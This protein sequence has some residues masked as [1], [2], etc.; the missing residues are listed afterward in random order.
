[1]QYGV[2]TKKV[3]GGK[4]L[5]VKSVISDH[6]VVESAY[7]TGDF[8]LHPE[9]ALLVLEKSLTGLPID[10]SRAVFLDNLNNAIRSSG[11]ELVG[12]SSEDVVDT[13]FESI[14]SI[15]VISETS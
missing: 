14:K 6:G 12:F 2:A 8:F 7:L 13:F 15:T 10:S 1:M 5:R 9:D 3:V 11:A 4:L